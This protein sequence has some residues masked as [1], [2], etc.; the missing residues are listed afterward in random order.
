MVK[1]SP[2]EYAAPEDIT[3]DAGAAEALAS[4]L[5][6]E[7]QPRSRIGRTPSPFFIVFIQRKL[8]ALLQPRQKAISLR[9]TAG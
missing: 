7:F 3:R 1:S 2:D 4:Y 9:K 5:L 8:N 6:A